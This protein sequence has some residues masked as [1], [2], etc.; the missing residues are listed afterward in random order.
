VPLNPFQ[1]KFFDATPKRMF[2]FAGYVRMTEPKKSEIEKDVF[3][4]SAK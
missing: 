4:V 1:K 2:Y 3:L